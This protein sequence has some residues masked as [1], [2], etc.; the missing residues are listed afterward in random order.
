ML[1]YLMLFKVSC[2]SECSPTLLA[3]KWSFTCVLPE[4]VLNVARLWEY[5]VTI[6][7]H[8]F[9]KLLVFFRIFVVNLVNTIPMRWNPIKYLVCLNINVMQYSIFTCDWVLLLELILLYIL[10]F[11]R[12]EMKS[13]VWNIK[14]ITNYFLVKNRNGL[15]FSFKNIIV[16][17]LIT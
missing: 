5:F 4:V 15:L 16:C 12:I 17:L 7:Y 13:L 8:A 14:L 10:V 11:L 9:K 2:L 3:L 6:I 1:F